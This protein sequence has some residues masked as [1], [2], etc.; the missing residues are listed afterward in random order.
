M[1]VPYATDAFVSEYHSL[2]RLPP[3]V[4]R[5]QAIRLP[6]A[7]GD[8]DAG[9]LRLNIGTAP[10]KDPS[11]C[12]HSAYGARVAGL[13]VPGADWSATGWTSAAR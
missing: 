12:K 8:P 10:F 11:R 13:P 7:P 1:K 3:T 9:L 2:L 6:I 5:Y 4:A